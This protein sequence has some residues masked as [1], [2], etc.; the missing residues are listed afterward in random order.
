MWSSLCF[1]FLALVAINTPGVSLSCR[2]PNKCVARNLCRDGQIVTDGS[3][4]IIFRFVVCDSYSVCC[5]PEIQESTTTNRNDLYDAFLTTKPSVPSITFGNPSTTLVKKVNEVFNP[6][7]EEPCVTATSE[8]P[9]V[10]LNDIMNTIFNTLNRNNTETQVPSCG[11]SNKNGLETTRKQASEAD[12]N[13]FPWVVIVYN[14]NTGNILGGGSLIAPNVVLTK[15]KHI[16][17]MSPRDIIIIAGEWHTRSKDETYPSVSME[18]TTIEIHSQFNE[19]NGDYNAA[20]LILKSSFKILPNISPICL[21]PERTSYDSSRCFV[22]GWGKKNHDDDD[23]SFA[24]IQKKIDLPIVGRY[25]CESLLRQTLLGIDFQLKESFICAGGEKDKDA[26]IG[27]G[28][29]PLFCPIPRQKNR[30]VQVGIVNWGI[31]CGQE[32]VPSAY[33]SVSYIRSWIDQKTMEH[34]VNPS[35]YTV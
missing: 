10:T 5:A 28:G 34:S 31:L 2:A 20:L 4:I 24:L 32:N 15:A 22:A 13:E 14:R 18:V 1:T 11:Y 16:S 25:R 29:A 12:V 23:N 27:D 33:T 3:G 21:A 35:Y 30:F 8:Q 7:T 17:N 6:D 19:V 26:C 9:T